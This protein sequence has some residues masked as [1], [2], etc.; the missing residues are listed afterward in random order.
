MQASYRGVPRGIEHRTIASSE[1]EVIIFEP[2]ETRNTGDVLDPN[3]LPQTEFPSDIGEQGNARP[4]AG[5]ECSDDE[6]VGRNP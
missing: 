4:I 2:A 3:L 5:R 1:A 6:S